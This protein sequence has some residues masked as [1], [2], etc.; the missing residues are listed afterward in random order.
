MMFEMKC[1]RGLATAGASVGAPCVVD[2]GASKSR[3]DERRQERDFDSKQPE[4]SK[5]ERG[6]WA[7]LHPE[8]ESMFQVVRSA[9]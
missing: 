2:C 3:M 7:N 9:K 5:P 1:L 6:R 8:A 4:K